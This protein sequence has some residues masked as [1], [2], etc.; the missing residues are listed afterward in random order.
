MASHAL[1]EEMTSGGC[2][3]TSPLQG[4]T[5]P[6]TRRIITRFPHSSTC[7]RSQPPHRHLKGQQMT[8]T[9]QQPGRRTAPNTDPGTIKSQAELKWISAALNGQLQQSISLPRPRL[10]SRGEVGRWRENRRHNALL[11]LQEAVGAESREEMIPNGP[12]MSSGSCHYF[13][14]V[15]RV[16]TGACMPVSI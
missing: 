15:W 2:G 9:S 1:F 5:L 13:K 14:L 10:L 12:Q 4:P 3:W 16:R 7:S 8:N 6:A 11:P